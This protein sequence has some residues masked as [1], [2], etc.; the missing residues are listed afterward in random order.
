MPYA[1]VRQNGK[2]GMP[3]LPI[4]DSSFRGYVVCAFPENFL[5][6]KI[7]MFT[8]HCEYCANI[9]QGIFKI[10]VGTRDPT[11]PQV[12]L[13]SPRMINASKCDI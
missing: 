11:N 5:K 9:T 6:K 2:A 10:P 13:K 1:A 7:P 4:R 8:N 12:V 3:L